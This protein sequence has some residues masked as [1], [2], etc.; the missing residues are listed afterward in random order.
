MEVFILEYK[1]LNFEDYFTIC[2]GNTNKLETNLKIAKYKSIPYTYKNKEYT[3]EYQVRFDSKRNCIQVILQQTSSKSDWFVNLDFPSK[4]YDKFTFEGKLIQL[5]VHRGWGNMWLVC[6]QTIRAEIFKLLE[7]HPGCYIEVIG[8]SLGSGLAQLAAEDI[9]FKFGIKP[10]LYTF[11]SVKPFFGKT[12]Y[13]FVKACCAEAYNFYDHCDIVGYM[14]PFF[15]WRAIN[16]C[17]VKLEKF[18]IVKLF[19][20]TIYHCSYDTRGQYSDYE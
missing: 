2:S 3:A 19:K 16:H 20:P 17:K 15:G 13:D 7:K 8:W 18:S 4:I 12:T 6:Q 5:S 1:R 10:Y 9:Y 11:G 14:V